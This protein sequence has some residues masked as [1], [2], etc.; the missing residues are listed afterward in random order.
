MSNGGIAALMNG[1]WA[2]SPEGRPAPATRPVANNLNVPI[3]QFARGAARARYSTAPNA[4]YGPADIAR[5]VAEASVRNRN[6]AS[7]ASAKRDTMKKCGLAPDRPCG[8][9]LRLSLRGISPDEAIAEFDRFTAEMIAEMKSRGLLDGKL[10]MG[11]DF[12]NILRYD[13]KPGPELIRG[14]DKKSKTSYETYATVQCI[15]GG[16]RLVLGMLPHTPGDDHAGAVRKLLDACGRHGLKIGTITLDRGFYSEAVFRALRVG[17]QVAHAVPQ[18]HVR[19]GG[20]VG[21]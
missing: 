7:A 8:E 6:V 1:S 9:W 3:V 15:V 5:C 4:R 19:K 16:K 13:K 14:G 20:A 21:L 18:Q 11:I 12:H 2:G 17:P 10:D